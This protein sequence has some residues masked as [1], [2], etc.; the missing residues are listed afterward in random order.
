MTSEPYGTPPAPPDPPELPPGVDPPARRGLRGSVPRWPWWYSIAAFFAALAATTLAGGLVLGV[1]I[2]LGAD[3]EEP[4]AALSLASGVLQY[5]IFTVTA[6]GFAYLTTRPRPWHFGFRRTRLWRA[7]GLTLLGFA[8]FFTVSVAYGLLVTPEEQSTLEVLGAEESTLSL[9]A[10]GI[11]VIAIAPV[12]EELF[13]RGFFYGALRSSLPVWA[14]AVVAG[15]LFGLSHVTTGVEAVPVLF[16]FG[17]ILC[18]L[19]EYTGSLYPPIALHAVNNMLAYAMGTEAV[20][21]SLGLGAA[22]LAGCLLAPRL[23]PRTAA[24]TA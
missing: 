18:L 13:F 4:G 20:L 5:A 17:V 1:A 21:L 22:T 23:T 24:A 9:I 16:A 14:A 6:I 3:P 15:G 2:G 8:I 10:A 7:V 12:A 11:M 19:Y